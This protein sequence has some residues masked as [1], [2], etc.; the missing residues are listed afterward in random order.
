MRPAGIDASASRLLPPHVAKIERHVPVRVGPNVG[1]MIPRLHYHSC[2][3]ARE[4]IG[5]R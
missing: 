4:G 3:V 2:D 5:D 1:E